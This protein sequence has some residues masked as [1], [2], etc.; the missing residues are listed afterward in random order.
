VG[1]NFLSEGEGP[2][3]DGGGLGLRQYLDVVRRRKWIVL[4]VVALA[5]AAAL[6][7]SLSQQKQYEAQATVVVGQ[8]N[9]L[10]PTTAS[11]AV[12][13]FTATMADLVRSNVVAD[14]VISNLGLPESP[15]ELLS[16]VGV[17]INPETANVRISFRDHDPARATRVTQEIA[18]VFSAIVRQQFGST[19][20]PTTPG[21]TPEGPLSVK[22]FDPA[23][24]L[25]GAVTPK[26]KRNVALAFALGLVLGLL[27]AFLR[28]HFDRGIRTREQIEERFGL[29]VIGQIPFSKVRKG[30][31]RPVAWD[32]QGELGEAVSALRAN[33]QYLAVQRP[34]RTIL[35][36]SGSPEQ[37][38]TTVT[39]NLGV[40]I[41]RSGASTAV[42]ECD[43][44][45]P[46]LDD[47]LGV[48]RTIGLTNV[49]VGAA[50]L[51]SAVLPISL[52]DDGHGGGTLGFLGSGPLPPNPSELLS[53]SQMTDVVDRLGVTYDHVL[54]DSPPLLLVADGLEL[55]RMVDGVILV[56]R[57][58]RT[59]T[60]EAAE[61]RA[62]VHR[63]GIHL[64]GVVFT[65]V[66][67]PHGYGYRAYG[68]SPRDDDRR[69]KKR[70]KREKRPPR[71]RTPAPVESTPLPG[72]EF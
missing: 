8:G 48:Q 49:L 29:P 18:T 34:L 65:D 16:K 2:D 60:V 1:V 53:S 6:A 23:H 38:K 37:G 30:R 52:P 25:P 17:S 27:A 69:G 71:R 4:S 45:R 39:V 58:N 10:F 70:E 44:R 66:A 24:A 22:I 61:L 40:A 21:S 36:T 26:T 31:A 59:T 13:P 51:E 42:V 46:R 35:V 20:V 33:L 28:D 67:A 9:T 3:G 5:V 15:H 19:P 12:Q 56:V 41:A 11:N 63:L 72:E 32:G 55:A 64:V 7:L 14:R 43:L 68:D 47:A 50:D 62:L 54:I 57:R